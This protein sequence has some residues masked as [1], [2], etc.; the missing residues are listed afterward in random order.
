MNWIKVGFPYK[1]VVIGVLLI[2]SVLTLTSYVLDM[3]NPADIRKMQMEE[4]E[5]RLANTTW[6]IKYYDCVNCNDRGDDLVLYDNGEGLF[7]NVPVEWNIKDDS[8]SI[9]A[10]ADLGCTFPQILLSDEN[11]M[12]GSNLCNGDERAAKFIATKISASGSD[13]RTIENNSNILSVFDKSYL[14]KR[15]FEPVF[16]FRKVDAIIIHSSFCVHSSNPFD[17]YCVLSEY[18]RHGVAAH[19]LID[20]EGNIHRLVNENNIAFHAG[21]GR[22]PDG[23]N[24][25]NRRSLGIELINSE[26]EAPTDAQYAALSKLVKNIKSRHNI[27]YIKGHNQISPGR[28]TDPWKFNWK[29]FFNSINDVTMP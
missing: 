12:F 6:K 14:F 16:G 29:M 4:N 20:R 23:Y 7:E 1:P 15:G 5:K 22:M 2:G 18:K 11:M 3:A 27:R 21:H 8:V 26:T 9:S 10:K 17:L 19:Y 13:D 28:K 25:I 24:A